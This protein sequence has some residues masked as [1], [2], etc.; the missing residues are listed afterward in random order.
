MN[1]EQ[2]K[3]GAGTSVKKEYWNSKAASNSSCIILERDPCLRRAT[4]NC[5]RSRASQ[6]AGYSFYS[7]TDA[8]WTSVNIPE[9]SVSCSRLLDG[10]SLAWSNV[11]SLAVW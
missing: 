1:N 2:L 6:T 3:V 10:G 4:N 11:T 8:L 5:N 7:S 9:L